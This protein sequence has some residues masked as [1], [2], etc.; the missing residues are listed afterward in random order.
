MTA[1]NYFR[2]WTHTYRTEFWHDSADP[3]EIRRAV[4]WGATGVTTNPILMPRTARSSGERWDVEIAALKRQS[5]TLGIEDICW[6]L[7]RGIAEEDAAILAPVYN[8]TGGRT[9]LVCVQVNPTKH[10]DADAMIAQALEISRWTKNLLIKIPVTAAGL[11]A[12]EELTARGVSTTGTTSFSVPQVVGIAEAFR[13]GLAKARR[14]DLDRSRLHSYAVIMI[15]RLDDHLRDVVRE[16]GMDVPEAAINRAGE[17]VAKKAARIFAAREY[18]S[19]LLYSSFRA[20][21]DPGDVIGGPH[22]VTIPVGLEDQILEQD[23]LLK[24]GID[25]PIPQDAIETLRARM[26]DFVRAYEE[27]GMSPDD[28]ADFGPVV[29]TQTQFISG[30]GELQGYVRERLGAL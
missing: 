1:P 9:G 11:V 21:H 24:A 29:K 10:D 8:R 19:V 18:E 28:F 5:P 4:T 26:V 23:I 17:A 2:R 27:E 14:K 20:Y 7:I 16:R 25:S 15:G 30:Y 12:I 13:R 22:V 3:A 6:A